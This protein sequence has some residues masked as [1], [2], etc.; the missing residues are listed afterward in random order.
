VKIGWLEIRDAPG[1][2]GQTNLRAL[3]YVECSLTGVTLKAGLSDG[4]S[5]HWGDPV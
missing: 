5:I 2:Q 1:A 4:V 3:C